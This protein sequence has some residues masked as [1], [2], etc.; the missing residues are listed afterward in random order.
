[1]LGKGESYDAVAGSFRWHVP[2][3]YNIGVDVCDCHAGDEG[4]L[5]LVFQAETGEPVRYTFAQLKRLSNRL[6]N[7]LGAL[8]ATRGDRIGILLPQCPEAAITHVATYKLGGIAVP[9]FTLFGPDALE[10]RLENSGAKA[11]VTDAE[12]LPKLLGIWERLPA[13]EAV[14][15]TEGE[16]PDRVHRFPDLLEK[17]SDAY[18]PAATRADDPALIIY[19][20]GTTG[21]P[22]GAL[23]AHRV[24]LGHLPGVEFPHNLFPEPGDFFWTPADWA[25]IGGLI[26]VLLP[27]WHHGVPVLAHRSR[28]FDPEEA[29]GLLARHRVRNVFMPPTALKMMQ[30]VPA[31]AERHAFRLRSVGS[32]GE[33][34]GEQTLAW[35]REA[36]GLT[37]NE[38]YGQTEVNL[39]VGNCS[40]IL[41]VRPG[42]MGV[43]VPGHTVEVVD[44]Q[45]NPL[46][47][48]TRGQVAVR[49]PDPV[50]FLEYWGNPEATARKFAREW[51]LTGDIAARD[52]DGYFWYKGREDDLINSAGYRIGP[53]EIEES[54]SRHPAVL[55]SAVIGAPDPLRNEIVKAYV[56]LRPDRSPSRELAAEIQEHVKRR[57]AA[58]EYPRE[59][60]FLAELPMTATGK[61]KRDTL[62][63]L[64]RAKRRTAGGGSH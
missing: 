8:G 35:G 6:A 21:P 47:P 56:V 50:M 22:K 58:H 36:L 55:R 29:F 33:T 53:S 37:V 9:L 19:T 30:Q 26:D 48:G 4:R 52:E 14:L 60:E 27:S 18:E 13:L 38:F 34:L 12:N 41:E 44:D 25:W 43:A 20:S 42:S 15:V 7:A 54:L 28:K 31:P 10:Y 45:G 1:M 63:E 51:C 61:I 11:V 23:H 32:G 46:P 59:I 2:E 39:I 17:G 24:L 62:R 57:L 3:R 49:R 16:T 5:A 40:R 64:D